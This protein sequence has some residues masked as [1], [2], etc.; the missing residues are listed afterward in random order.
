MEGGDLLLR[1]RNAL[2]CRDSVAKAIK[3][4]QLVCESLE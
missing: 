2:R 4:S 3:G 1:R